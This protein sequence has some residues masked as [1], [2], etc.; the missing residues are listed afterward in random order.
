M[1]KNKTVHDEL[2][3]LFGFL[4]NNNDGEEA[5][6]IKTLGECSKILCTLYHKDLPTAKD[7]ARECLHLFGFLK[8]LK[9][10]E[11]PLTIIGLYEALH[12]NALQDLYPY[13]D[14]H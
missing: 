5:S 12:D 14:L 2:H 3:S 10:K 11:R 4:I 7:F 1:E 6:N 13:V 8:E 9:E